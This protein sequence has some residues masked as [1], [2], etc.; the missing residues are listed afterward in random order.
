MARACISSCF[1]PS[2]RVG[3]AVGGFR[4][5]DSAGLELLALEL[6]IANWHYATQT[7]V[8]WALNLVR[9]EPGRQEC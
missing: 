5:L 8:T 4:D 1:S 9:L 7:D 6:L 3:G 2:D